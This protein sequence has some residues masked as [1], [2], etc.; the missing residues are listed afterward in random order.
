MS[1]IDT[2]LMG[3]SLSVNKDVP[4]LLCQA[5]VWQGPELTA[6]TQKNVCPLLNYVALCACSQPAFNE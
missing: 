1:E 5:A 2:R 4:H 6:S 3:L